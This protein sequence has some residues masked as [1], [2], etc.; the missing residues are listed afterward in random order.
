MSWSIGFAVVGLALDM[1]GAWLLVNNEIKRWSTQIEEYMQKSDDR[2]TGYKKWHWA[3]RWS[4]HLYKYK[5]GDTTEEVIVEALPPKIMG[6]MLLVIG[7]VFQGIGV[8][9]MMIEWP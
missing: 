3:I 6:M 7:F 2:Y 9:L 5:D 8:V 1:W 4:R